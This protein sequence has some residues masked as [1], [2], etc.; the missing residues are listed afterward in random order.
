ML[1]NI[2]VWGLVVGIIHFV[3]VGIL[4]MNPVVAR[5]YNKA[6]EAPALRTWQNQKEYLIKMFAGTQIEVFLFTG[7]YLYLRHLFAQ[8][9]SFRT[10]LIIACILSAIRVYPRFWNMLIQTTY[11]VNL[12]IV[13]FINGTIGM[14]VI[15]LSLWLLPIS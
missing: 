14:F 6:Q 10:A 1:A 15:V 3:V 8:P 13:E 2:L 11:P 9:A 4:Y 12:L 5:L 7:A